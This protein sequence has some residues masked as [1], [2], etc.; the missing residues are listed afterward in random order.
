M[1][2]FDFER[3][4][5]MRTRTITILVMT[6][7][8]VGLAASDG[9]T[10]ETRSRGASRTATSRVAAAKAVQASEKKEDAY[11]SVAVE[12][13]LLQV[14]MDA[15]YGFGVAAVPQKADEMVT[16]PRLVSCLADPNDGRVIDAARVFVFS[17]ESADIKCTNTDYVGR[18]GTGSVTV[19][20]GGARTPARPAPV[21]SVTYVSYDSG[22]TVDV[23][24]LASR[25]ADPPIRLSLSYS[26]SGF[27]ISEAQIG[28]PPSTVSY[29]LHTTFDLE[30][31]QAIVAGSKQTGNRGLFL[32]VRASILGED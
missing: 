28:A 5:V 18:G 30:D 27:F 14:D 21:Q 29:D 4:N 25:A 6:V 26:H 7:C 9:L 20:S 8:L 15:L 10:G 11:L 22:T 32:V 3:G 13:Y 16:V 1:W 19:R 24:S 31:G 2:K 17:R 23:S 12:T